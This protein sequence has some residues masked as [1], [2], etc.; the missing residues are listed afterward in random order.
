[1]FHRYKAIRWQSRLLSVDRILR[2]AFHPV[3]EPSL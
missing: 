3:A 2:K 1:M